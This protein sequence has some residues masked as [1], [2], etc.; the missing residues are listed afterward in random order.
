MSP[1]YAGNSAVTCS[2]KSCAAA[3][4]SILDLVFNPATPFSPG[5]YHYFF[6]A[7]AGSIMDTG[8]HGVGHEVEDNLLEASII[9]NY[10]GQVLFQLCDVLNPFL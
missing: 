6:L 3:P 8:I 10:W 1:I 2:L 9:A 5:P 7:L 4:V